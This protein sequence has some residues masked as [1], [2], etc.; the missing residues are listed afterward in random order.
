[1]PQ[2]SKTKTW[3]YNVN[4]SQGN[5]GTR[6]TDLAQVMYFFKS[7]ATTFASAPWTVSGSSD[8]S[9][10]SM[11]GTDR[12]LA[13]TNLVWSAAGVH[14]WIVLRQTGIASLFEICIDLNY[15]DR[16]RC[17]IAITTTGFGTA[18]GGTDGSTSTRPT[19]TDEYAVLTTAAYWTDN[20]TTGSQLYKC[21][22]LETSDGQSTRFYVFNANTGKAVTTFMF[23]KP[24]SPISTWTNPWVSYTAGSGART[25]STVRIADINDVAAF[26]FKQSSINATAFMGTIFCITSAFCEQTAGQVANDV[27]GEYP[28]YGV[29]LYSETQGTIGLVGLLPDLYFGST[30]LASGDQFDAS[31]SYAWSFINDLIIPWNG[32]VIQ[33]T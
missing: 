16:E 13:Y 25:T 5:T 20:Y 8:S 10:S 22:C 26:K 6:N 15:G 27:S 31:P 29:K 9:A 30:A 14:S 17:T 24:Q 4:S 1:M 3:Q 12:W 19:A 18:Y 7:A 32:T 11:D 2:P 21:H 33:V 28:F 23:E